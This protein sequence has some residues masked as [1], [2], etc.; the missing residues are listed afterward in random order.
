[1]ADNGLF[2][3]PIALREEGSIISSTS[4]EIVIPVRIMEFTNTAVVD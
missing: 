2:T 4:Q 3:D 1:M